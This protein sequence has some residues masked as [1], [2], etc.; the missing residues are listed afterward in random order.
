MSVG[1][2]SHAVQ[3]PEFPWDSL[4]ESGELARQHPDGIV[5]LSVGTPVDPVPLSVRRAL[6]DAADSPGYP[7]VHGTE[8]LRRSYSE[9]LERSHGVTDLDPRNVLPTIGSKELVASLPTQLG[10]GA[11]DLVAIPE[12]AYPTYEVGVR[13]CGA[14]LVRSDDLR[15]VGAGRVQLL[16]L[17]SPSNPTGRV[18][19]AEKLA[20]IVA[21]ARARGTVVVSDEC[22]LDLGW[23]ERPVSVLDPE[24]CRG[25]HTG[26]LAV[27]SMSKR[28]NMAGYR[29]GFISGDP[30]LIGSLLALRRHLGAIVPT[31]VQAAAVAALNDDGHVMIQR[32]RYG[33]R[34]QKLTDA[35]SGN[36]FEIGADGSSVAGLYLWATRGEDAM[37][38]V[39]WFAE[40]GILVAPGTFYGPSGSRHVRVALTATDERVDSA[41][42]RLR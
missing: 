11:G 37:D 40:R 2:G 38:T 14:D 24:V 32:S 39:E 42:A 25:D 35:L 15:E 30:A 9:W 12:L 41:V 18:L 33:E 17:N 26:L 31:P 4:D 34:R 29:I 28:S 1:V 6:A 22:Y 27:H 21:W 36:G 7:T 3:L 10:L 13:M 20:K 5:D 8:E 23:E 16:W 19:S